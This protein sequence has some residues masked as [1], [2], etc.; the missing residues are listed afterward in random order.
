MYIWRFT[1][2]V[3]NT[4]PN[5]KKIEPVQKNFLPLTVKSYKAK[6]VKHFDQ[7]IKI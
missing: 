6:H 3:S 1:F 5:E 4:R 7:N 2:T